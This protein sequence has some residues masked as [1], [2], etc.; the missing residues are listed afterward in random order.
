M[1]VAR[2]CLGFAI[3]RLVFVSPRIYMR[4]YVPYLKFYGMNLQ[5]VPRYISPWSR[6]DG[7]DYSIIT[8]GHDVVISDD[9]IFLTHDYAITRA[10]IAVGEPIEREVYNLRPISVGD[11]SFIGMRSILLP[12]VR[13]GRNVIVGAGSVVRGEVADDTIVAGNPA[14]PIGNTLEW[15]RSRLALYRSGK[16]NSD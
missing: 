1:K 2:K 5:G 14:V 7:I 9:V 13:I 4:A 10:L 16:L 12:G 15:G 11:N 8:L 3:S 6:F